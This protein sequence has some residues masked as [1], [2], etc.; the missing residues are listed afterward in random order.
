MYIHAAVVI[1]MVICVVS[2]NGQHRESPDEL[3]TLPQHIVKIKIVPLRIIRSKS[4]YAS[5]H[6][7][8]Y[9]RSWK[10]FSIT[11]LVKFL[12]RVMH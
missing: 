5:R 3:K 12:G 8:H 4:K 2:V 9:I 7:I 6:G 11:S 1:I 10:T